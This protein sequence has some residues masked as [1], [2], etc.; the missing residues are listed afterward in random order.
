MMILTLALI[1]AQPADWP[2]GPVITGHGPHAPVELTSPM[3]TDVTLAH[4]FDSA[5]LTE[6]H[7]NRT[8]QSA[9]RFI[10]M[11]AA[12]GVDP[13]NIRPAVVIHGAAVFSVVSDARF[14]AKHAHAANPNREL[15]EA[16]LAA[17]TRIIVCGQSAAAQDVATADLLP[18]VEMALSAMTAHALL[19]REGYSINPF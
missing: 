19:Q 2:T 17:G 16:L 14:E 7:H 3:P 4:A 6:D 1:A 8:L 15:V 13:G 11:H 5:G 12:A 18:G 10:N 9:A